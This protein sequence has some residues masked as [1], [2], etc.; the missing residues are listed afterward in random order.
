MFLSFQTGTYQC[1]FYTDS[2]TGTKK[3]LISNLPYAAGAFCMCLNSI[4]HTS[5]SFFFPLIY[6]SST[7]AKDVPVISHSSVLSTQSGRH[8][9]SQA[10]LS[11]EG[12]MNRN[13]D[14]TQPK[15]NPDL[16]RRCTPEQSTWM[17]MR[18][19]FHENSAVNTEKAEG[20]KY[21]KKI[22]SKFPSFSPLS[23]LV[24]LLCFTLSVNR[25]L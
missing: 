21:L 9:C 11:S 15:P 16:E 20:T 18:K 5:V 1:S 22:Y 17:I 12:I 19:G 8:V 10:P 23:Q 6:P 25:A 2:S 3:E 24:C 4:E 7:S 13:T 14:N